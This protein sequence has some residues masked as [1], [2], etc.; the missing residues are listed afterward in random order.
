MLTLII[1][2]LFG[3]LVYFF[4]DEVGIVLGWLAQGFIVA[5]SNVSQ[6]LGNLLDAILDWSVETAFYLFAAFLTI[7]FRIVGGILFKKPLLSG[8]AFIAAVV[9]FLVVWTLFACGRWLVLEAGSVLGGAMQS[10]AKRLGFEVGT[11]AEGHPVIFYPCG[12]G[13]VVFWLCIVACVAV[14]HPEIAASGMFI[15][16]SLLVVGV[17]WGLGHVL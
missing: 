6:W 7:S 14:L 16:L 3:I 1:I 5:V 15:V 9:L 2:M 8:F 10:V 4:R 12:I 11:D 13:Y 17:L